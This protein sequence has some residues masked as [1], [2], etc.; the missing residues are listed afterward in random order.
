MTAAAAKTVMTSRCSQFITDSRQLAHFIFHGR[1]RA[2]HCW[3]YEIIQGLTVILA[4]APTTPARR[5]ANMPLIANSFR[6][7]PGGRGSGSDVKFVTLVVTKQDRE[8][9]EADD[10]GEQR[11]A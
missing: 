3:Q 6:T 11:R 8:D 10:A 4:A 2:P 1:I 5:M 9:E 7:L